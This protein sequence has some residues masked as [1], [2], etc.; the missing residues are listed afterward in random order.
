MLDA[1]PQPQSEPE[2]LPQ[3][4]AP[5]R[6]PRGSVSPLLLVG[7]P[8][9]IGVLL[10]LLFS[11]DDTSESLAAP[12]TA[13]VLFAAVL[14]CPNDGAGT[15]HQRAEDDERAASAMID[16]YPF[17]PEDGVEAVVRFRRAQACFRDSGDAPS[18]ERLRTL[19]DVAQHRVEG[20]YRTRVFR[21][22]R[23]LD[24][25]YSRRALH[26][27][28]ALRA[29]LGARPTDAYVAWLARV[30]HA[31]ELRLRRATKKAA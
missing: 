17:A 9:I 2:P 11:G 19:G 23:A 15:A 28:R 13:P 25:G 31:L 14:G 3:P 22:R 1:Q 10:W 26:E 27:V 5:A 20:D 30:E 8:L 24:A 21:L 29:M 7:V 6:A 16:R 4:S 12:E 18:A